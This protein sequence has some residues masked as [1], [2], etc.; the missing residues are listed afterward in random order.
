MVL[1]RNGVDERSASVR[2]NSAR[3]SEV[4]NL[5]FVGRF[6]RQ[7]GFDILLDA[8]KEL[9]GRP[10]H[11]TVVG[12]GVL[13][14]SDLPSR[15]NI[16]YVGWLDADATALAFSVAD[17]LVM[18]SRWEGFAMVPLEAMSHSLAIIAS[19][20]SSLPEVVKDGYNGLLFPVG[21]SEAL[22]KCIESR[23]VEQWAVMGRNGYS[24]YI[25]HFTGTMMSEA[26]N[27]VYRQIVGHANSEAAGR[28]V[29][30]VRALDMSY[31][32]QPLVSVYIPT[33]DR[34]NL[35]KR[36][37]ESVAEQTYSNIELVIADDC[38]TDGTREYLQSL[39][40]AGRAKV[41]LLPSSMGACVARNFAISAAS[42][43]FVTGLDDDD[44][45]LPHRITDFVE[46][47]ARVQA[48][49][50]VAGLFQPARMLH[51]KG[52]ETVF[53]RALQTADDL[54]STNEVGTHVFAPKEHFLGAGLFD[55]AMP[56]WQDWD[57]W[58]RMAARY[59]VFVGGGKESY[60]WDMSRIEGHTTNKPEFLIRHGLQLF[61]YKQQLRAR[62]ER[63]GVLGTLSLYPQIRLS[64][65]E[66]LM[67]S[68]SKQWRFA[69]KYVARKVLGNSGFGRLRLAV[70]NKTIQG[71]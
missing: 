53:T 50:P 27:Q 8:M 52:E 47:W 22:V 15:E 57:L 34:L 32:E 45:F 54:R 58:V 25:A 61:T 24:M 3:T 30:T 66:V 35:L 1:I 49:K 12:G 41:V 21:D 26:T 42:G 65:V 19:D 37:V 70:K 40:M 7:K 43:K 14:L 56:C 13:H 71:A 18:P 44:Y 28:N 29:G 20:C 5:L 59:G 51:P 62:H 63:L 64:A 17:V 33:K 68:S 67:L 2:N 55:P 46:L 6:D 39:A 16:T 38:S 48:G 11:L 9:E 60:V 10:F 31:G 4:I 69:V 36:A 23:A